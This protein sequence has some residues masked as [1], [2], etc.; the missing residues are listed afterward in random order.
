MLKKKSFSGY[1]SK[2]CGATILPAFLIG[3]SDG[4]NVFAVVNLLIYFILITSFS[5]SRRQVLSFSMIFM[6]FYSIYTFTITL[7]LFDA[8]FKQIN[9]IETLKHIYSFFGM[10]FLLISLFNF[11]DWIKLTKNKKVSNLLLDIPVVFKIEKPS[12]IGKRTKVRVIFRNIFVTFVFSFMGIM[13]AI[14]G[15]IWPQDFELYKEYAFF[16]AKASS[17]NSVYFLLVY[18]IGFVMLLLL[19]QLL[20]FWSSGNEKIKNKLN[21]SLSMFK[22]IVS[23]LYFAVGL[24]V[25]RF[26]ASISN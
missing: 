10:L 15:F 22:I 19:S 11:I 12:W 7:G 23:G 13:L 1:P 6:F 14:C 16:S 4:V 20:I 3:V 17:S 8:V 21:D 5:R 18:V 9:F 2:M 26:I 25:I 24:G